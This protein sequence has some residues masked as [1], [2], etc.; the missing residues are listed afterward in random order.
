[1]RVLVVAARFPEAGSKGDQSRAFSFISHL[2]LAHAV[3]VVTAARASSAD[4]EAALQA[5]AEVEIAA[6]GRVRRVVAGL[7]SLVRLRPAQVGWMMPGSAWGRAGDH[8]KQ[9]DVVLI[10]TARSLRGP[11]P[12]PV[13][14]DHVD[15]LSL[16]MRRRAGG[17]EHGT[18]RAVARLEAALMQRWERRA[19]RW[20]ARQLATSAEDAANLPAEPRC[21]VIPVGWDAEAAVEDGG[22]RDLDV[23]LSG[24]MRYPPNRDAAEWFAYE[25]LPEVRRRRPGTT[26]L[27]VGREASSLRLSGVEIASDVPDLMAYL[28]RAKVAI[29]P[30]RMGTGSP[31]KVIE[32]AASGAA[33][34]ATPWAA[35]SFGLPA[36]GEGAQALSRRTVELLEDEA[37]RDEQVRAGLA[38]AR[39]HRGD[40][41]ARSL[42][43][44]L[45]GAA[46]PTP[47]PLRRHPT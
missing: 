45:Q 36:A 42:E 46:R 31:Y 33:V 29:A 41:L 30:L 5:V 6:P 19:A 11:L 23:V 13:V 43:E 4:A 40:R 18:I 10:N 20:C 21:E 28:R 9:A 3:A 17:P 7:C 8:A 35:E 47:L 34:V 44:I 2:A 32:A 37:L 25:I 1:V 16:N 27:V 12:V 38:V 15:A 14:L 39:R 22:D 26:A 24:N